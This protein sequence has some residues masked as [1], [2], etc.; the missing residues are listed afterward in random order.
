MI[1]KTEDLTPGARQT[2][3]AIVDVRSP[4]EFAEDHL[5]G[6]INLP[7]LDDAQRAE[8]G[9]LFVQRSKFLA[10]RLGASYVARNIAD[11][12]DGPLVER[13]GGFQPLVYCWRGGQRSTAMATVMDQVGW[14]V[15]Q[16]DGGYQTWRRRVV[17]A[18]YG[19]GDDAGVSLKPVLL[20]GFTGS[21]KTE[22]LRRLAT[23]GIQTLDLEGLADHR[24]SLFGATQTPQPSQKA[25][26]TR[27]YAAIEALDLSQPIIVEAESSRIGQIALPPVLWAAMRTAPRVELTAPMGARV[28]YVVDQYG[29]IGSDVEALEDAL[30]RLPRH[31]SRALIETWRNLA[32]EG[33]L[34]VLVEGLMTDH[35]DPAYR[36]SRSNAGQCL[37]D[38]EMTSMTSS[39]FDT[40][41][42]IVASLVAGRP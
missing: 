23:L 6:A 1:R 10:R 28:G 15:T 20:D 41:A 7:V 11:H 17:G 34:A 18:L 12:L 4:S 2:Y 21:G 25:F 37:G 39:D 38:V 16:L 8:V 5:P 24:G 19:G 22:I 26:E 40:A 14:P 13:G 33:K 27:L 36:R 42:Q 31:H 32:R 29:T 3:D 9:T 35:Y 30:R